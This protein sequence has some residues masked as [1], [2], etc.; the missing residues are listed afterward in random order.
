M[1]QYANI[2]GNSSVRYCEYGANFIT[3]QFSSGRPY[4]YSD[5]SA[6]AENIEQ[7]KKLADFGQGLGSFIMR[8]VRLCYVK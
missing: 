5:E 3:V 2:G 4:T 8:N 1:K 7:M 6:G